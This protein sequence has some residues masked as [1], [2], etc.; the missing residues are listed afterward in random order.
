MSRTLGV[1]IVTPNV[2]DVTIVLSTGSY[3]NTRLDRPPP[4][5]G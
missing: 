1:L 3:K 2:R 5:P 4:L